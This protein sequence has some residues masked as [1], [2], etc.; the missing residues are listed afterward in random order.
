MHEHIFLRDNLQQRRGKHLRFGTLDDFAKATVHLEETTVVRSYL[1]YPDP[2]LLK[3]GAVAKFR[4]EQRL[5]GA[6]SF[7]DV[8]EAP[9]STHRLAANNLRVGVAFQTAVSV[10]V[11]QVKCFGHRMIRKLLRLDL[12]I[13]RVLQLIQYE[14]Q[15]LVAVA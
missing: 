6:D 14:A 13:C 1:R 10:K 3:D 9:H 8:A 7:A 4:R 2:G 12:K 5:L 11:K 15:H